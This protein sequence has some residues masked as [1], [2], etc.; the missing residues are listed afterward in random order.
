M[1][2][3]HG[4][5]LPVRERLDQRRRRWQLG[6]DL[7]RAVALACERDALHAVQVSAAHPRVGFVTYQESHAI[8]E[9][10]SEVARATTTMHTCRIR[11]E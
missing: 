3:D 8:G 9:E 2:P 10:Y 7:G 6:L 1:G 5:I 4:L 11:Q